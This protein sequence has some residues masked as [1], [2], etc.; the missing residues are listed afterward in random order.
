VDASV[1]HAELLSMQP[2]FDAM[3]LADAMSSCLGT[4]PA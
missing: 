3:L 1:R 4:F 2:A